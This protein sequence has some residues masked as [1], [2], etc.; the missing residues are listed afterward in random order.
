MNAALIAN[1]TVPHILLFFEQLPI[2]INMICYREE[3]KATMLMKRRFTFCLY[4]FVSEGL[5][6]S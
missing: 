3:I 2:L 5:E 4:I 6:A 1:N